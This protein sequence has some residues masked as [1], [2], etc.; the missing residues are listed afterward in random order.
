MIVLLG[1]Q[2]YLDQV[3]FFLKADAT[4]NVNSLW[5]MSMRVKVASYIVP[6]MDI[7]NLLTIAILHY[8]YL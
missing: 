4:K 8:I 1:L 6:C 5:Q 7:V 3:P 2:L